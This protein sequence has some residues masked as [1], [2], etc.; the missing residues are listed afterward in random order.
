MNNEQQET[1][2]K[3]KRDNHQSITEPQR[4]PQATSN[5][6]NSKQHATRNKHEPSPNNKTTNN[7]Q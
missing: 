1:I 5:K 2:N 4:K 3:E 7:E 6:Q